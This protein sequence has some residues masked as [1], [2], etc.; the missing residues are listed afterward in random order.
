MNLAPQIVENLQELASLCPKGFALGMHMRFAGAKVI[1]LTYPS[2]W[3]EIYDAEGLLPHDPTVRWGMANDGLVDWADLP[4]DDPK[5]VM[6]RARAFGLCYGFTLSLTQSGS[7][8]LMG[9]GRPDR[10][11]STPEKTRIMDLVRALHDATLN[12]GDEMQDSLDRLSFEL[13][14]PYSFE[15]GSPN[16]R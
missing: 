9:T 7:R 5:Q 1:L 13:T 10:P 8:S 16:P 3:V 6:T 15:A 12:C 2:A 11:Y 4:N 14:H